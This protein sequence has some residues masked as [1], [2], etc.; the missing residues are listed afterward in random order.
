MSAAALAGV[1]SSL[2]AGVERSAEVVE[3][4]GEVGSVLDG[5]GDEVGGEVGSLF[6]DG[7]DAIGVE[8]EALR[9]S[10]DGAEGA[11]LVLLAELGGVEA[12][13]AL[14]EVLTEKEVGTA[15]AEIFGASLPLAVSF[16]PQLVQMTAHGERAAVGGGVTLQARR[17]ALEVIFN[18]FAGVPA[19]R[20]RIKSLWFCAPLVLMYQA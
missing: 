16:V 4:F 15:G 6:A 11:E 10:S 3:A 20:L 19:K 5:E 2:A 12:D 7:Q 1:L 13:A 18:L 17:E 8:A 14:G 9:P